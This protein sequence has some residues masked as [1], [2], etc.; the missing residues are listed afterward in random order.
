MANNNQIPALKT[1]LLD[2]LNKLEPGNQSVKSEITKVKY[3]LEKYGFM[4]DNIDRAR[5]QSCIVLFLLAS[6]S[7]KL[8]KNNLT[9]IEKFAKDA[10]L[11]SS[12][13]QATKPGSTK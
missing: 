2:L 12:L 1:A 3:N 5:Y 10:R 13:D 4:D 6:L 9:L 8:S 7:P 11:N